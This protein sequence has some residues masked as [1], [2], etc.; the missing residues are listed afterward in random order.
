[1]SFTLNKDIGDIFIP[2][3]IYMAAWSC[4]KDTYAGLACAKSPFWL[5]CLTSLFFMKPTNMVD[6]YEGN[7][8]DVAAGFLPRRNCLVKVTP[9]SRALHRSP[10]TL[11]DHP[12]RTVRSFRV[13][14][15]PPSKIRFFCPGSVNQSMLRKTTGP[16][17]LSV[18]FGIATPLGQFVQGSCRHSN[19]TS[20][21]KMNQ[22]KVAYFLPT[23]ILQANCRVVPRK[24]M[25]GRW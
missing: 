4:T 9:D 12:I 18:G 25:S 24:I 19:Q 21:K 14:S 22:G 20:L 7:G 11:M 1:M 10:D 5:A 16:F 8:M 6:A 15:S 13:L 17:S 2:R 23:C 3:V